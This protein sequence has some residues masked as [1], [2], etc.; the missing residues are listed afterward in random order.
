M[1]HLY[2]TATELVGVGSN[3]S[4]SPSSPAQKCLI[5]E[6]T[7]GVNWVAGT[8]P[9]GRFGDGSKNC[10]FTSVAYGHGMWLAVGDS[11]TAGMAWR[12]ADGVHWTQATDGVTSL[13]DANGKTDVNDV[14][15]TDTGWLAVGDSPGP[16]L[17][18]DASVWD[19]ANGS[20]WLQVR[21]EPAVFGGADRQ[22]MTCLLLTS[23]GAV[24]GGSD[25]ST[26]TTSAAVW[27]KRG[28]PP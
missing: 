9:G 7:D 14:A 20:R 13:F 11:G 6:S 25:A 2:A 15:P 5:W 17:T 10:S 16:E 22:I 8:G 23:T 27:V 24:A 18:G 3:A 4:L 1:V 26:G 28:V 19:S 21:D 12:S